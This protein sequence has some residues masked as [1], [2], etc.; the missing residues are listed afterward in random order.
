MA[1]IYAQARA[2]GIEHGAPMTC[3]GILHHGP[4]GLLAEIDPDPAAV[5]AGDAFH[6]HPAVLDAATLIGFGRTPLLGQP[7]IPMFLDGFRAPRRLTGS[8]Y[9]HVPSREVLAESQDI[10]R[11]SFALYDAEGEFVARFDGLTCKR[12]RFPELIT[13]DLVREAEMP[14]TSAA[15]PAEAPSPSSAGGPSPSAE[16]TMTDRVRA[17]V[18]AKLGC[19]AARV[20]TSAGFYDLGLDSVALVDLSRELEEV[21]GE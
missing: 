3:R 1:D 10:V 12:I 6:I 5:R 19:P 8:C 2:E 11:N 13:R 20:D 16:A 15:P 18:A 21:V 7:F 9:V 17:L 4:G 14:R